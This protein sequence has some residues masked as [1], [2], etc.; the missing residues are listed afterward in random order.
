MPHV[1]KPK[2]I[3]KQVNAKEQLLEDLKL[4]ND[5]QNNPSNIG[6]SRS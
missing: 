1:Q 2:P 5:Q 3:L 6:Q 4:S